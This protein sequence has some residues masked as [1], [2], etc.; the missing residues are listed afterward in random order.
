MNQ[1]HSTYWIVNHW[2]PFKLVNIVSVIL[3]ATLN[4]RICHNYN[5]LK[6]GQL[7][8]DQTIS[9]V[10]RLWFEVLIWYW[11]F[12][13]CIDLPNLQSITIGDYAFSFAQLFLIKNLNF[14]RSLEIG[15]KCFIN[16][17]TFE[18]NGLKSLWQVKIGK[19]SFTLIDSSDYKN[20]DDVLVKAY[21]I[22]RSFHIVNCKSLQSISIGEF[23]FCDYAGQFELRNLPVLESISIGG[24]KSSSYNFCCS[25]FIVR[26][27]L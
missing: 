27:I 5:P 18:I 3:L 12:E 7:K 25:S 17:V 9:I 1:N 22:Y 6:L 23:S 16:V 2:N 4:W 15:D 26:S 13:W 21:N 19:D 20:D 24:G 11:I 14:L 10:V 8:K